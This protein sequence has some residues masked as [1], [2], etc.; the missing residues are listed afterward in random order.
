MLTVEFFHDAVCGWCYLQ[1]PRLRQVSEYYNIQVIHRSF[2]LQKNEQEM[3][4]RFGSLPNAKHE[5]LSHWEVCREHAENPIR[6]NI[7]GMRQAAFAY[8]SGYLAA[9]GSKA[10]EFM[11]GQ[12]G[13]WD[14]FDA[15]QTAHLHENLNIGDHEVAVEVARKIGLDEMEFERLI[16][17][18]A[19]KKAVENDLDRARSLS[20][21]TIPS[22]YIGNCLLVSKTLT[23]DQ[24]VSVFN[25]FE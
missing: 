17:G 22:L 20:I 19:V 10:A 13:H 16:E 21:S 14:F 15:I 4:A 23:V 11:A 8:P 1:S 2:V 12:Q 5:I 18:S 7:E 25:A 3:I 24:L 9:L 6:F